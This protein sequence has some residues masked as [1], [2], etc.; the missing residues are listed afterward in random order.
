L[1]SKG[2]LILRSFVWTLLVPAL[3]VSSTAHS[4]T[5]AAVSASAASLV[6]PAFPIKEKLSYH[7]EWRL[8]TAGTADVELSQI[9]TQT[10]ET[11]VKLQSAGL[12]NRLYYV[13]DDYQVRTDKQFCAATST[14]DA[15]EGKRRRLTTMNFDSMQKRVH[16]QERDLVRATVNNKELDIPPCTRE[17]IGALSA[18]RISPPELGKSMQIQVT[19]GKRLANVKIEAEEREK[20]TINGKSYSTVRYEAF[21]FDNVL[22]QRKG[23]MHIWLTED[24]DRIPVQMRVG[25]GFPVY[26]ILILLDKREK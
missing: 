10:W 22:Y 5:P 4:P 11:K 19:D 25:L 15:T 13:H 18:L 21:L 6:A 3:V 9:S 12:V 20:I 7:I 16:Y 1:I 24:A 14:L 17:V 26:N 23:M 8:I 2:L